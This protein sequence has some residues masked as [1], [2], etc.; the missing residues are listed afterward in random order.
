[1]RPT[2][3]KK[4]LCLS[5][6]VSLTGDAFQFCSFDIDSD[7]LPLINQFTDPW[8]PLCQSGNHFPQTFTP[9]Q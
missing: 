1:M 5:K 9:F 2:L 4:L 8:C 7:E 3:W 6:Q